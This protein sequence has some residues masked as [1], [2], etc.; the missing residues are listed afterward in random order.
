VLA[1]ISPLSDKS[2]YPQIS[3]FNLRKLA[4]LIPLANTVLT[5][6]PRNHL[7]LKVQSFVYR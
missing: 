5:T 1:F 3:K 2:L 7:I 4:V 6:N